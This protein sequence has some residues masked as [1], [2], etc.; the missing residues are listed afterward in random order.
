[1]PDTH[2]HNDQPTALPSANS[3]PHQEVLAAY[4]HA[5][6][7]AQHLERSL[8]SFVVLCRSRTLSIDDPKFDETVLKFIKQLD[9]TTLG[10]LMKEVDVSLKNQG[11]PPTTPGAARLLKL[12]LDLRNEL[13]HSYFQQNNLLL[14]DADARRGLVL[15]LEHSAHQFYATAGPFVRLLGKLNPRGDPAHPRVTAE[16]RKRQQEAL[17]KRLK[18]SGLLETYLAGKP[19]LGK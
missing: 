5:L 8:A 18:D 13:A 10:G 11:L 16:L 3:L 7:A 12:S 17:M 6:Q 1:M 15:D 14:D 19:L 2:D 4:G 9:K